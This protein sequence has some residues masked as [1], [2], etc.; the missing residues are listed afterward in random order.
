MRANPSIIP[1]KETNYIKI[2]NQDGTQ[3]KQSEVPGNLAVF[4]SF[5]TPCVDKKKIELQR[6]GM[7]T[8]E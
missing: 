5:G 2:C 4:W 7:R 6:Y 3:M 1:I 8:Q